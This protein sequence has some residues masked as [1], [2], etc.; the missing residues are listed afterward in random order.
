MERQYTF[1]FFVFFFFT[2]LMMIEIP[3]LMVKKKHVS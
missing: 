1:G 3:Q 2:M